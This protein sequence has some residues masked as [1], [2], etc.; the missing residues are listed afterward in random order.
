[1][2]VTVAAL[3]GGMWALWQAR[4]QES[5]RAAEAEQRA[6]I[7]Q[8]QLERLDTMIKGSDAVVHDVSNLLSTAFLNIEMVARPKRGEAE[9]G[10]MLQDIHAAL[11][12]ATQM[13]MAL[14]GEVDESISLGASTAGHVRL[15]TS[16][17]RRMAPFRLSVNGSL[18]YAGRS[19]DVSRVVQNLLHNAAREAAHAGGEVDVR[20][21]DEALRI[22]NALRRGT[23]LTDKI[24]KR[25]ESGYRASGA[26]G[27]SGVGLFEA[28]RLASTLGW[29][30]RF[31][32][33]G[34]LVHFW[35]QKDA[36][37]RDD[38]ESLASA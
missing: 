32:T 1:M 10:A 22:S 5:S 16:L 4:V 14:R 12:G 18:P 33:E 37:P 34:T 17:L 13:L 20:L 29:T 36:P 3:S 26:S 6:T 9:Q 35:V 38:A 23:E 27:A 21:T 30:I 25:G 11:D 28:R 24:F 7:A 19:Q 2:F 15:H 8:E 31:E